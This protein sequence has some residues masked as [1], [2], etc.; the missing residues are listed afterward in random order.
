[1]GQKKGLVHVSK[2]VDSNVS[3]PKDLLKVGDKVNVR[4][5]GMKEGEFQLSMVGV[6]GN[7]KLPEDYKYVRTERPQVRDLIGIIT[8]T[9]EI[10]E[11]SIGGL[12]WILKLKI[13]I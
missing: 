3:H 2:L 7:P 4:F 8:E 13:L 1:M 12:Q 10:I 5:T 11:D 6:E 9:T